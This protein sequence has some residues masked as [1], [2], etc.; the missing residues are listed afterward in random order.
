MNDEQQ[1]QLIIAAKNAAKN[2]YAPYSNF[3]V[4]ASILLKNGDIIT[5]ANVENASYGLTLCAETVALSVA[6]NN[7]QLSN[8][9][10]I[11]VIGGLINADGEMMLSDDAVTPCGRCRQM[12]KEAADLSN[13]DIDV[14]C[15]GAQNNEYFTL[16]QLLPR[17]FGPNN[18]K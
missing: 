2:A 3:H 18:L 4:G 5:G 17:A 16:S 6:A 12:I 7:G 13:Y 11:A 1:N 10:A 15:I 9:S 8:V 14:I